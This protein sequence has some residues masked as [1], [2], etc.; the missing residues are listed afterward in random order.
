MDCSNLTRLF[1]LYA[2]V[3]DVMFIGG[4]DDELSVDQNPTTQFLHLS[5]RNIARH[6]SPGAF[7]HPIPIVGKLN[8]SI[9]CDLFSVGGVYGLDHDR[10]AVVNLLDR[11]VVTLDH[12]HAKSILEDLLGTGVW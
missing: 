5:L 7:I 10:A 4:F 1:N 11:D 12:T 2:V 8:R 3:Q 9:L 6:T